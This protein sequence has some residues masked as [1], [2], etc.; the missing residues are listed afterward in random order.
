[1][2]SVAMKF[3]QIGIS[4]RFRDLGLL[5]GTGLFLIGAPP[6]S[7]TGPQTPKTA[8]DGSTP[9]AAQGSDKERDKGEM[10]VGGFEAG[11]PGHEGGFEAGNPALLTVVMGQFEVPKGEK[12]PVEKV[13]F[14]DSKI[15]HD[16]AL[17]GPE[18]SFKKE[19]EGAKE[20]AVV[21]VAADKQWAIFDLGPPKS[22]MGT[23]QDFATFPE[24]SVTDLGKNKF[25]PFETIVP[26]YPMS[27][28]GKKVDLEKL[29]GFYKPGEMKNE[30]VY[31]FYVCPESDKG[32]K[33][34][35]KAW[36]GPP[37]KDN[38]AGAT[39]SGLKDGVELIVYHYEDD[40][41]HAHEVTV[42]K[43]KIFHGVMEAG[44]LRVSDL[45][46]IDSN[47]YIAECVGRIRNREASDTFY[48]DL[49]CSYTPNALGGDGKRKKTATCHYSDFT[50]P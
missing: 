23:P 4:R 36:G 49:S 26:T 30:S 47:P 11:N 37:V 18:C 38:S 40:L 2:E 20:L 10:T 15:G 50:K 35:L 5:L 44:F 21:P 41:L 16:E 3:R 14:V 34:E 6:C 7:S 13:V 25:I 29:F 9:A 8:A 42:E 19:F 33:I 24:G 43:K 12:C 17:V 22:E 27:L 46:T 45:P 1:M 39:G 28:E 31:D 48:L 32:V